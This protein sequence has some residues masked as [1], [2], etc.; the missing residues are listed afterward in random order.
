MFLHCDSQKIGDTIPV[1]YVSNMIIAVGALQA[2]KNEL[3]ILHSSTSSKN[4]VVWE[5]PR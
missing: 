1:D 3:K 4:P 5:V 2:N